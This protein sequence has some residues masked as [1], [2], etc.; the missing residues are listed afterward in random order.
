MVGVTAIIYYNVCDS[1]GSVNVTPRGGAVPDNVYFVFS[2]PPEEISLAAFGEWYEQHVRDI[3]TVDGFVAARRFDFDA[4]SGRHVA[5]DVLTP[6][7]VCD[8]RR[9]ARGDGAPRGG[10]QVWRRA[11][12]GVVR[13]RTLGILL[14]AIALEG[15]IDLDRLDHAYIVFS[16]PAAADVGRG[17]HR[18]VCDSRPRELHRDGLRRRLA[19]PARAR[20]AS[21]RSTPARAVHAAIYEVHGELPELR[22]ALKE[23]ADAGR[24]GFPDW[25][26]EILF[27]SL[28]AHAASP[29]IAGVG[30]RR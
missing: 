9:S 11:D 12:S 7:T 8:R 20:H 4:V 19:L 10:H 27:A 24:V 3:L 25:F 15:P 22:A 26:G 1:V 16:T 21:T 14:R 13:A 30:A 17:V 29:T 28:D 23:A 5:D 6:F 18:L 2:K